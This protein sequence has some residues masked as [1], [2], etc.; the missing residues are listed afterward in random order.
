M[1]ACAYFIEVLDKKNWKIN[2]SK[3]R[4]YFT[5][6]VTLKKCGFEGSTKLFD[7]VSIVMNLILQ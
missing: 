5:K 1:D 2:S 3:A 4:L 7:Q 6:Y